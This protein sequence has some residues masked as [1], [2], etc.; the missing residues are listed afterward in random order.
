MLRSILAI[1]ICVTGALAGGG[2]ETTL[3][4][5]NG[6]SPSSRFLANE[7]R[8]L[9]NIPA[10]HL[11]VLKAV[12]HDGVIS[13]AEFHQEIWKPIQDYLKRFEGIDLIVYSADF[14]YGVDFKK[15]LGNKKPGHQI[16]G[17]AS[18]T[19]VTFLMR[20]IEAKKKWWDVRT[21]TNRYFRLGFSGGRQLTGAERQLYMDAQSLQKAG[22]LPQARAKYEEFLKVAPDF[23]RVWVV[24][25]G[26]LAEQ[27]QIDAAFDALGQS[28]ARGFKQ[29]GLLESEAKFA[30]M[31]RDKRWQPLLER[32]R[33]AISGLRP[34]RGFS[35]A[36]EW[37]GSGEPV[38]DPTT[39]HRYHLAVQLAY[40]GFKGNSVPEALRA[41]RA[42]ASADATNPDGT[43]YICKNG[44]V[45]S[46]AREPFF[47]AAINA[48]KA[49]NRKVE[50]LEN[51]KIPA[52]K[53]DVIGAVVGT[54]GFDWGKS[55]SKMLPGAICE[56]LTSFGAH[57]G[58][59]GQ[60]KI[61]EFIRYGAA[62][63][64]GT[65]LEPL[66]LHQ[67]FP[68][69]MIHAFYAD[70]C[71]L[72]EAFY[73][74]VY[75]PYQLMVAGDGLCQPFAKPPAFE[76]T[77]PEQPWTG[78]VEFKPVGD[79]EFEYW[80]NGKRVGTGSSFTLD[81]ASDWCDFRVVAVGRDRIQTRSARRFERAPQTMSV[82]YGRPI[83]VE[84]EVFYGS[85]PVGNKGVVSSE[86]IGPGPARLLVKQGGR[87][88]I[89][90][91]D[92]A[93]PKP[94]TGT[95]Q[96]EAA[97][98]L[99]GRVNDKIDVIVTAMGPRSTGF[100][101]RDQLG[102][103]VRRLQLAGAIYVPRE[104]PYQFN[105]SG[106]GHIELK[107]AGER[108]LEGSLGI[109]RYGLRMLK[110]GWH[111]LEIDY[112]P[113]GSPD[114]EVIVAGGQS[115]TAPRLGRILPAAPPPTWSESKKGGYDV[116]WKK[117]PKRKI[118]ALALFPA[119]G[120]ELGTEWTVQTR[121][122]K[123]AKWKPVSNLRALLARPS[124]RP[125]KGKKSL[126]LAV[127]LV[128]KPVR[129]KY[130][131]VVPKTPAKVGSILVSREAK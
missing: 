66:A 128:F 60:T 130:F 47:A 79:A 115:G 73:Q 100:R 55:R 28:A 34:T 38:S 26:C 52:N 40:T 83:K 70:G 14:P 127:E 48:L 45:R 46:T 129:S 98:G 90:D 24:Y 122:S 126:P 97:L 99:A 54:A 53:A 101:L 114:L 94:L 10:S 72:A 9:R 32:V 62:G 7:Y 19:G 8:R 112:T 11:L 44:N 50:L 85:K 29:A 92:V 95:T 18:L 17:V 111:E 6:R 30:R 41:L 123:S 37:N 80:Q 88:S 33:G 121:R 22:R 119:K 96:A 31:R 107:F 82:E 120:V 12:S 117:T 2:P 110:A 15:E 77:V 36:T 102:K 84:G 49:R 58:T 23:G 91:V 63:S 13:L 89:L 64:A 65:V 116:E 1:L 27:N 93:T 3:L 39:P 105:L 104:G 75:S 16:G 109:Q 61:A 20:Q 21:E 131:R 69:P 57:Y 74:S 68:N 87:T 118:G 125:A 67:K 113:R 78:K 86:L 106:T 25:A 56:H 71:S 124:T 42:S 108:V 4:V 43:V 103:G 5:V 81:S 76:L 51:T 35:A 59:A